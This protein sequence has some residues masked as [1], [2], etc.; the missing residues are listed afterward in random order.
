MNRATISSLLSNRLSVFGGLIA[1]INATIIVFLFVLDLLSDHPNAYVGIFIYLVL[2]PFLLF[3]LL[4]VP[5]GMYRQWRRLQRGEV[6]EPMR[7]P[8]LDLNQPE[9]RRATVVVVGGAL[10]YLGVSAVGA[11]EAF[12]YSESVEFCGTICHTVMEPEYVAYQNSPHARVACVQCHVGPG[13]DWFVRSKMSGLYQVYA[14][15]AGVYPR[16]IDTPIENLRPAQETCEQCH[17]PE[18]FFG[19]QQRVFDHYMYDEDNTHWRINML[20]KTGGGDPR[21]GEVGGIHWHMNIGKKYEYVARDHD[22]QDIPWVRV[23]DKATGAV[24]I[25][26]DTENPLSAEELATLEPRTMDCVDC[27]NRPSHIYLSPDEA[28]DRALHARQIDPTI[29]EIKL[30]VVDAMTAEDYASKEAAFEAI[31]SSIKEYYA[32]SWPEV[33]DERLG[34]LDRAIRTAQEVYAQNIFPYMKVKWSE[35]PSN[36][37]HFYSPGCMRCHRGELVDAHGNQP[38]TAC[39]DC[40]LIVSQGPGDDDDVAVSLDGLPFEHPEDIGNDWK[41]M[42]CWECHEGVAP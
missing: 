26:Q 6:L 38:T 8:K 3:G 5:V 28:V 24:K 27:H 39:N 30:A 29:P 14:V 10:L 15:L 36:L 7:W 12:H 42:G 33:L 37:G 41:K 11:Y 21:A 19:A 2:P 35:Y 23:T 1:A 32:D 4:L 17:W 16:P 18:K 25:Y 9:T 20:V 13:A 31:A 22:R 34:D 40:H